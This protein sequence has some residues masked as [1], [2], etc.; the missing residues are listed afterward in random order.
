M[1]KVLSSF[2]HG[3]EATS[4]DKENRMAVGITGYK[5]IHNCNSSIPFNF[6]NCV[7]R[8]L[9][10]I[11]SVFLFEGIWLYADYNNYCL[12][13]W[14]V[15]CISTATV[16]DLSNDGGDQSVKCIPNTVIDPPKP[17]TDGGYMAHL[18]GREN[19]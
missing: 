13:I 14:P 5:P 3:H 16:V 8:S 11:I 10:G 2:L 12:F 19:K 4:A 1:S 9:G 7:N 18:H 6:Y 17:G 15:I